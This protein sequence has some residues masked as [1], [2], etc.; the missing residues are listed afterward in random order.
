M[1]RL[2]AMMVKS[3]FAPRMLLLAL[4]VAGALGTGLAPAL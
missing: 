3:P 4:A 2:K 1:K